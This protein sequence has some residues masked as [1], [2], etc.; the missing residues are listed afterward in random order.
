[1]GQNCLLF[2]RLSTLPVGK[3]ALEDGEGTVPVD[4]THAVSDSILMKIAGEGIFTEG[5]NILVEGEYMAD[6]RL[7]AYA[8]GHPPSEN[9]EE[10]RMHFG[11]LDFAGTG[12][13]PTKHVVRVLP[14]TGRLHCVHKKCSMPTH[15]L[16]YSAKC[17]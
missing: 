5:A 1:M 7:R 8:I 9:R 11:H 16:L 15:V 13:V 10:A 17:I 12:A 4:L 6:E 14:L 3:Y 2:G